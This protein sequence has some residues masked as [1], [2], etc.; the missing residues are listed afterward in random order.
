MRCAIDCISVRAME[1]L[2]NG[3]TPTDRG[4]NGP[5]V[6]LFVDRNGLPRAVAISAASTHDSLALQLDPVHPT[7]TKPQERDNGD[8]PSCTAERATT[9]ATDG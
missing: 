3:P 9:T 1:G 5:K 2:L 6:H 4:K 8:R 7:R